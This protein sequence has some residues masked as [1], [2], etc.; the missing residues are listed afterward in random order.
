[1]ALFLIDG[2]FTWGR[3]LTLKNLRPC[4]ANNTS[5]SR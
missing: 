5:I 4:Y 3:F 2:V 1:M